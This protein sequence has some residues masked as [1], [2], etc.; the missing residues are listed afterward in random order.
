MILTV[1][2]RKKGTHLITLESYE[3]IIEKHFVIN[4]LQESV[5][6]WILY[7]LNEWV[8]VDGKIQSRTT[9]SSDPEFLA[10]L[11]DYILRQFPVLVVLSAN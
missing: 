2:T 8:K 5:N 7:G 4:E 10:C 6:K 11:A 3:G 9:Q 1:Y